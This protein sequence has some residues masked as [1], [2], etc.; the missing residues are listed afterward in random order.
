MIDYRGE[1]LGAF[2]IERALA[3]LLKVVLVRINNMGALNDP[4]IW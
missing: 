4:R 2:A 1:L 3:T